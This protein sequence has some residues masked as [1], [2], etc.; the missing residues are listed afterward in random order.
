[1]RSLLSLKLLLLEK[2][3][4]LNTRLIHTLN[5]NWR[6]DCQKKIIARHFVNAT[7]NSLEHYNKVGINLHTSY[8]ADLE[9]TIISHKTTTLVCLSYASLLRKRLFTRSQTGFRHAGGVAAC[10]YHYHFQLYVFSSVTLFRSDNCS[11]AQ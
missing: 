1:M 4:K 8:V 2:I 11:D 7:L 3:S 10:E 6:T 9:R 5:V